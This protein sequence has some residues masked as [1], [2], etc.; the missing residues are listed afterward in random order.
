MLA[1][2]LKITQTSD[3]KKL[4]I[5]DITGDYDVITNP[6]G[7]GAPNPAKT[8]F[9]GSLD[10]YKFVITDPN[11]LVTTLQYAGNAPLFSTSVL[12][13]TGLEIFNSTLGGVTATTANFKDTVLIDGNWTIIYSLYDS[14]TNTTY[15]ASKNMFLTGNLDCARNKELVT[16]AEDYCLSKC[17][18]KKIDALMEYE[19]YYKGLQDAVRC[20]NL[21]GAKKLYSLLSKQFNVDCGCG[22]A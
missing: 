2:K 13:S 5:F 7:Y 21:K 20:G 10:K 4:N 9:N 15:T 12:F 8:V 19:L 1:L 22:C 6:G 16:L 3:L 18:Y 14:G 11:G 17:D